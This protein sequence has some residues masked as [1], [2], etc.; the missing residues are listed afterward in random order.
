MQFE[1]NDLLLNIIAKTMLLKI[2][3]E[4][5][6]FDA[7][8]SLLESLRIYLQRKEALDN[9]RKQAFKN[10]ISLMKKLLKMSPISRVQRDKLRELVTSTQPLM[11]RDWL[12]QQLEVR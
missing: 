2:Y 5:S 8:E 4:Q 1:Y 12:L 7:F 6:E 11:E 9:N 3:F 10:M